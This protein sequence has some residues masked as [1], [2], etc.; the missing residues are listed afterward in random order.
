MAVKT[1]TYTYQDHKIIFEIDQLGNWYNN[2]TLK[3]SW[4]VLNKMNSRVNVPDDV[5]ST[6]ILTMYSQAK[7][8][9]DSAIASQ[10]TT[11]NNNNTNST[12]NNTTC[13]PWTVLRDRSTNY[14]WHHITAQKIDMCWTYNLI[15]K[16]SWPYVNKDYSKTWLTDSNFDS[17]YVSQLYQLK[18]DVDAA[19]TNNTNTTEE[20]W[21]T[22]TNNNTNNTEPQ[23]NTQSTQETTEIYT[24]PNGKKYIIHYDPAKYPDQPYWFDWWSWIKYNTTLDRAKYVIDKANPSWSENDMKWEY[25]TWIVNENPSW[26]NE[27]EGNTNWTWTGWTWTEWTWNNEAGT[28][29]AWMTS[30]PEATIPLTWKEDVDK[31]LTSMADYNTNLNNRLKQN[32]DINTEDWQKVLDKINDANLKWQVAERIQKLN[33]WFHN[34]ANNLK[35]AADLEKRAQAIYSNEN[36][37]QMREML[38]QRWY[39]PAK[40]APAVVFKAMKDRAKI[41]ADVYKIQSEF[42]KT[43][44]NLEAQRTQ[45]EDQIRR[46]WMETDKWIID[47]HAEITNQIQNLRKIYEDRVINN[48]DRY[49]MKPMIDI[50]SSNWQVELQQIAKEKEAQLLNANP[51]VKIMEASKIFWSD[52]AYVDSSVLRYANWNWQTF[53]TKAA[54]SIRKNKIAEQKT[55]IDKQTQAQKDIMQFQYNLQNQ[56]TNS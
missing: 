53:L 12:P 47:K 28:T 5:L 31:Y 6:T 25:Y 21:N 19:K 56:D 50:M 52:W 44:A 43:L 26:W 27:W 23:N 33:E 41:S 2:I 20:S 38:I 10:Q 24:A 32:L 39:N 13:N 48:T 42:E 34:A 3:I 40:A 11:N 46:E 17:T 45:L 35:A 1:S 55:L 22:Q 37:R 18:K 14:N 49:I 30:W 51:T 54:E 4:P 9:I 8:D 15:L 7:K 29:T 36:V 16:V